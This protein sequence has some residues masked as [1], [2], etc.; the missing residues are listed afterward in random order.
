M[1]MEN[2][3][4][5]EYMFAARGAN[6]IITGKSTHNQ[7][8]ERLWRDVYDGVIVHYYTLYIIYIVYFLED[9]NL[10]DV[11]YSLH[12]YTLHY[13]FKHKIN[14][15]LGIWRETGFS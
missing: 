13:V 10:L 15:K 5:A 8:I 11:L 1:G 14:E 6:G 12:I 2:S 3:K 4:I 7:R 9:E